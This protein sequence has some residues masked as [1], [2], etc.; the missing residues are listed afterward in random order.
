MRVALCL[1]LCGCALIDPLLFATK[2]ERRNLDC[3]RLLEEEAVEKFPGQIPKQPAKEIAGAQVDVLVCSKR[4]MELGERPPRDEAILSTLTAQISGLTE[5]AS[6]LVGAEVVWHVDAF[7]PS[8]HV[9]QK[10]ASAAKASLVE[11]GYAV[12]DRVP[13]LPAGDVSVLALLPPSEQYRTACARAFSSEVLGAD[14]ALL[15]LILIDPKETQLHGGV[16]RRGEWSW[17]P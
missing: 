1:L 6:A 15:G 7:Y 17:L 13:L 5:R 2:V 12:S 8:P 10:I 16:C 11:R 14:D 3:T 9:G 4:V